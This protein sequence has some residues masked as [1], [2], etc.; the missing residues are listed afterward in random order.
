VGPGDILQHLFKPQT[1]SL[2]PYALYLIT[3]GEG[4]L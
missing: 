1:F 4:N 2:M 3:Y